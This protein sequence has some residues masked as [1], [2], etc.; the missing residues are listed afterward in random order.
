MKTLSMFY[1][2]IERT[3]KVHNDF[4]F[5]CSV[6]LPPVSHSSNH[7]YHCLNLQDNRV[8]VRIFIALLIKVF[9]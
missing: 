7:E 8:V 2:V 6:V 4:T 9:M 1:L 5:L 3:P